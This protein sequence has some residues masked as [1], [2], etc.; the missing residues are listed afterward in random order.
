MNLIHCDILDDPA[1][2]DLNLPKRLKGIHK[3]QETLKEKN[4]N[5]ALIA[6]TPT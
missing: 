4:E 5:H 6:S 2:T 1:M 3:T